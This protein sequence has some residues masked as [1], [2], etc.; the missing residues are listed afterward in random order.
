MKTALFLT[1]D[2]WHPTATLRPLAELLFTADAWR[3]V[4]TEDPQELWRLDSAPDL[5]L[6]FK[7]PIEN[8]QIPTPVWCTK[9][10]T[11]RLLTCAREH[12][13]GV[14]L[15]HA[16]VTDLDADH[17][18][19]R[20]MIHATFI[21]H[22]EA[23]RVTLKPTRVHPVL[24]G[25]DTFIFPTPEEHYQMEMP[26]EAGGTVIAQTVSSHGTQPGV[27]VSEY[28]ESRICCV[29]PAHTTA[30]LTCE[31]FVRILRNAIGWC[32]HE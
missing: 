19:V 21:G 25:V 14:I 16:A 5:F 9:T 6:S 2:Y 18:L 11:D 23:C 13:T 30:S 7:D 29:T 28:G 4:F 17:L 20:E 31:P 8:D 10:W 27:W 32:C 1:G 15:A 24:E 3:V 22:P 26:E 12:G